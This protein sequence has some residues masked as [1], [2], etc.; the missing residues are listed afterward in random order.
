MA[1]FSGGIDVKRNNK[2][3]EAKMKKK[4]RLKKRLTEEVEMSSDLNNDRHLTE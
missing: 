2:G 4:K 1:G 3:V